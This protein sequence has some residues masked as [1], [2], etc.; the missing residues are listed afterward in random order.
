MNAKTSF[1]SPSVLAPIPTLQRKRQIVSLFLWFICNTLSRL[2]AS[3]S[4]SSTPSPTSSPTLQSTS[5][6]HTMEL[7]S[8]IRRLFSTSP[9]G[10]GPFFPLA[11]SRTSTPSCFLEKVSDVVRSCHV[12]SIGLCMAAPPLLLA[13]DGRLDDEALDVLAE[14]NFLAASSS[15]STRWPGCG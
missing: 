6:F 13:V 12:P 3:T 2:E 5:A 1:P 10:L 14:E 9:L 8:S 15:M 4:E 11:K 7:F